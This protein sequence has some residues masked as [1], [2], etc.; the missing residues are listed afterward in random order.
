[1][2]TTEGSGGLPAESAAEI[3][4]RAYRALA[5]LL[6]DV[7]IKKFRIPLGDAEGLVNTV[8]EAYL[9]RRATV[10]DLER[11]LI[12]SVCNASRDYWRARKH[13]EPM[14]EDVE[15]YVEAATIDAE[16]R[17]VR[18]LTIAV[19]LTR[20]G[21]RCCDALYL[22]HLGGFSALEIAQKLETSEQNVWQ[23]LSTCRRRARAMLAGLMGRSRDSTPHKP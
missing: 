23:I 11:Y 18:S 6:R 1:M 9:R 16:E 17:L 7:S 13:L 4:E 19:T 22:H 15:Q 3:V 12:A 21:K 5:P 14:P 8:F 20:L 2:V 10:H